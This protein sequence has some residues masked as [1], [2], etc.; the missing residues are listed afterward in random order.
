[1]NNNN[2]NNNLVGGR[3]V[4]IPNYYYIDGKLCGVQ[5]GYKGKNNYFN[6]EIGHNDN[7]L[8]KDEV[9]DELNDQNDEEIEAI[10]LQ[11]YNDEDIDM[12]DK[13][14]LLKKIKY[15]ELCRYYN[16]LVTDNPIRK[17][18][19]GTLEDSNRVQYIPTNREVNIN[20]YYMYKDKNCL[21]SKHYD[22][23]AMKK[24]VLKEI[25]GQHGFKNKGN[26]E[27]LC[28]SANLIGYQ[29]KDSNI[30]S[31]L[32]LNTED[33][34]CNDLNQN[35][36]N[37]KN[38]CRW[39]KGGIKWLK[40]EL[41]NKL[42]KNTNRN[43]HQRI[44]NNLII[45]EFF[46]E[47]NNL[48]LTY[49]NFLNNIDANLFLS[50]LISDEAI[51]KLDPV[52]FYLCVKKLREKNPN[53]ELAD[54]INS[55]KD[56]KDYPTGKCFNIFK[57][58]V[59]SDLNENNL[60]LDNSAPQTS[61]STYSPTRGNN[62]NDD[63]DDDDDNH[64]NHEQDHN[65]DNDD[66]DDLHRHYHGN[67]Q[68]PN[69]TPAVLT[70]EQTQSEFE[71]ATQEVSGQSYVS[72]VLIHEQTQSEFQEA[73]QEDTT[74]LDKINELEEQLV[75]SKKVISELD[76][77]QQN[78]ELIELQ[79]KLKGFED[80][81]K[82]KINEL[83]IVN[84]QK[85]ELE[86]NINE[87]QEKEGKTEELNEL[88]TRFRMLVLKNVLSTKEK[89]ELKQKLIILQL[90][91][92]KDKDKIGLTNIQEELNRYFTIALKSDEI[93]NHDSEIKK[94]REIL[95]NCCIYLFII[96][97]NINKTYLEGDRINRINYL[98]LELLGVQDDNLRELKDAN[99]IN[100]RLLRN[101][102][103]EAKRIIK[104]EYKIS[105][106]SPINIENLKKIINKFENKIIPDKE[107]L[108]EELKEAFMYY[109]KYLTLDRRKI[110][111][112]DNETIKNK[113][114]VILN[115]LQTNLNIVEEE[116]YSVS[117]EVIEQEY[118]SH[119]LDK[120]INSILEN[121]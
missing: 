19:D 36:C 40:E 18:E 46:N 69:L 25:V 50:S 109:I 37:N 60:I 104:S 79:N 100:R 16:N 33:N 53:Y 11:H 62:N 81:L 14:E 45:N 93:L 78:E 88:K 107:K 54:N 58:S 101:T 112:Q 32:P 64:H 9:L 74:L 44:I 3:F 6:L 39:N 12:E 51:N 121:N 117:D 65:H 22:N 94:N 59:E 10:L 52:R 57:H 120:K 116:D 72:P 24:S 91:T 63:R 102:L 31:D 96:Q 29:F 1:M 75:E 47:D 98:I 95:L 113:V 114:F 76:L 106:D 48:D 49:D 99:D 38:I 17:L 20:D 84:E 21:V 80:K 71:Q 73:T 110:L 34:Y 61:L 43:L 90:L 4:K 77:E 55:I 89:D 103:N 26:K 41:Y 28:K 118:K 87:L 56:I 115:N 83:K 92:N 66:N 111:N 86:E 8:S 23:N 2:N 105:F 82:E 13:E 42:K 30:I 15:G 35:D 85:L 108:Y 67:L 119:N 5:K 97:N 7:Y 27:F 68:V 70:H